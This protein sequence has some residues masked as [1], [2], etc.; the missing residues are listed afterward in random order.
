MING[1]AQENTLTS[2]VITTMVNGKTMY[3]MGKAHTTGL[4]QAPNMQAH[5]RKGE[6]K[7]LVNSFM[8]ITNMLAASKKTG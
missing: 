2:M 5:G 6:W 4:R 1:V 8:P 7:E 3:G